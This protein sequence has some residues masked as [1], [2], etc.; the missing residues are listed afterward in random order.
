MSIRIASPCRKGQEVRLGYDIA[1]LTRTL[2]AA[3]LLELTL[4]AFAG[5]RKSVS[6]QFADGYQRVLPVVA[7]DLDRLS[8]VAVRWRAPVNLDL[9]AFE[10]AAA[11][12][13]AGHVWSEAPSTAEAALSSRDAARQGR[14]FLGTFDEGQGSGD[15]LEVYTYVHGEQDSG[16]AVGFALDYASRGETP[17]LPGCDDGAQA[18]V[19]FTVTML[20]RTGELSRAGGVLKPLR[21]GQAITAAERLDPAL[22]PVIRTR[23]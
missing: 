19:E 5:D 4:D 22:L 23:N 10:H 12:G 1:E 8:K 2:S 13:A 3:G 17:A 21:C 14:G 16:T 9:H 20:A 18:R 7:G 11:P 15:K 6:L